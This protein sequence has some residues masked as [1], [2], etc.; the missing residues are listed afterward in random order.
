ML[1]WIAEFLTKYNSD[2]HVISYITVRAILAL[3]TALLLSLWIGPKVI[4]RLQ[5]LKFGQV[6]R[7][8]GPESLFSKKG[9]PTMGGVMILFAIGVSTL[10]WADLRNP[11]VWFSLFVLFGY[12]AVGFVD[13]YRKITRKSTDGLVARWKYFWLS[14][15]ALVAVFGMYA[16]GQDTDATRLVVPFF[17]TVMPQLGIFYIVLAYFVIVGSSNAVNLTDG[18]DGLAIVPTI[19]VAG[20]FALVAWA[21][22]N[23]NFAEYLHIPYIKFSAELVVFCTAIVGAG[24]GFLWFN[25]YPA[26]VFMGDVGSLALGGALGVIAVLVRQEFLL[27]IM[28]GVFVMETLSVILQVGSYKLRNKQRIFLMAPIHH[29]FEKKGWPEPRVI[30]RFWIISL[31]LVL[32]GLVTLKLR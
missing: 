14:V 16:M 29:H 8:D 7:N 9:T 12:G 10:L 27:L 32:I 17:K 26:Q 22:G 3:L 24:L 1:V 4:R 2:F 31:M 6:V 11:Y 20:A 21:T 19:M 25:T 28:G 5:L 23:I 13:D 15:V 18:L 30:V